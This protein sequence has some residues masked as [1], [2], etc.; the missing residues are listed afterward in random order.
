MDHLFPCV[1]QDTMYKFDRRG[2]GD[3]RV[4]KSFSRK[5]SLSRNWRFLEICS[6][7]TIFQEFAVS[8]N[9][10]N[11]MSVAMSSG[12]NYNPRNSESYLSEMSDSMDD[13]ESEVVSFTYHNGG[14]AQW[15]SRGRA[16]NIG[17]I[18]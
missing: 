9:R 7:R 6:K 17:F 13:S 14:R 4:Q 8:K 5:L 12:A 3:G 2:G 15:G 18:P 10:R 16:S 11:R 1:T